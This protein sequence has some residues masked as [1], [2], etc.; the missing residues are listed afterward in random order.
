MK[1]RLHI[2]NKVTAQQGRAGIP[3]IPVDRGKGEKMNGGKRDID[4]KSRI[5]VGTDMYSAINRMWNDSQRRGR[6]FT[7]RYG[8]KYRVSKL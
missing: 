5:F 6:K 7:A 1:L 8:R 2:P 4:E 3:G